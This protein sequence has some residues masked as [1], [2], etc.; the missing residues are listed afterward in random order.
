MRIPMMR[1]V[2]LYLV[3]AM[4]IIGITPPVEAG[5]VPSQII[6]TAQIDRSAEIEK[7]QRVLEMKVVKERLEKF[8]YTADEIRQR[9]ENLSDHQIHQLAQQIDELRVGGDGLGVVVA[10]LVI[11]ILVIVILQLT[12][13]KVIVT[14]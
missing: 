3:F 14:K 4:F 7:I 10:L 6:Q 5:L 9:L 12:G 13:H 2:A 11:V 1:Y 8:G